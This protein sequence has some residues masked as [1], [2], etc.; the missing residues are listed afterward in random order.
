M[1]AT[2]TA[3]IICLA[4]FLTRADENSSHAATAYAPVAVV[5]PDWALPSSPTHKQ[6]PP[7]A[8][9]H[10]P[11]VNFKTAIGIFEGQSDIGGPLLPGSASYDADKQQY[12]LDSASYNIWYTRDEM[13]F[14]WKKMSGDISLAADITFPI[15]RDPIDRKVV[16]V[17]RQDLDDDS[18]EVMAGLHAPGLI[19]LAYRPAKNANMKEACKIKAEMPEAGA[20]PIRIGIEKHGDAFALFI[21]EKGKPMQQVGATASLRL[22]E[23]FY[24][25]IG[26]CSHIPD[27]SDTGVAAKVVL[28]NA[29]GQV[30]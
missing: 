5:V 6:V 18:A 30:H 24:V 29:A 10:R 7:P 17:I 13:R 2:L 26:F 16:L 19:H 11:S 20:A 1:A 25:G 14:I 22:D 12:T 27:K 23:P 15:A 3:L 4:P 28:E 21:G 8:G 9:F